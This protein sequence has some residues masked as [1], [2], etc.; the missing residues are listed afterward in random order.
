MLLITAVLWVCVDGGILFC[1]PAPPSGDENAGKGTDVRVILQSGGLH[2]QTGPTVE[3]LLVS[4]STPGGYVKRKSFE[5]GMSVHFPLSLFEETL[6]DGMYTFEWTALPPEPGAGKKRQPG[7]FENLDVESGSGF[8]RVHGGVID[9]SPGGRETGGIDAPLEHI[10]ENLYVTGRLG[11]GDAVTA[12]GTFGYEALKLKQ[13]NTWIKFE[14]SSTGLGYASNDWQITV[15]DSNYN[16]ADKFSIDDLTGGT[17][18]FTVLGGAPDNSLFIDSFG[19][20][21]IGTAT[22]SRPLH[23][24]EFDSPAIRLDNAGGTYGEQIWDITGGGAFTVTDVTHSSSSPFLIG[25]GAPEYSFTIRNNGNIGFGTLFPIYPLHF[26][27]SGQN[28]VVHMERSGGAAYQMI[29]GSSYVTMG[30]STNHDFHIKTNGLSRMNVRSNG[31]VGIGVTAPGYLLQLSGGAY[32]N[33]STWVNASSR[34]LKENIRSLTVDEA[35]D[36]LKK[37]NPVKFNYKKIKGDD[38]LGFIAEDAPELVVTRDHKGMSAMDVVAV[39]TRVVQRQ[40][41]ELEKQKAVNEEL[42]KAIADLRDKK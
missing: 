5:A 9:T 31:Y 16:G 26:I 32:C 34:D 14:D 2:F 4:V 21:G 40:Q 18:P 6:R 30:T 10:N 17:T 35:A 39:L 3:K 1:E 22:P 15:N 13:Y 23:I 29:A 24:R 38:F 28:V 20:V 27:R 8:F 41:E 7:N 42:K 11:I 36:A 33:G 37:L 19:E 12:T 25:R